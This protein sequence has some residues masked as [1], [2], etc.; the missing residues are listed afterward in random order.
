VAIENLDKIKDKI[1]YISPV[2]PSK[3]SLRLFDMYSHNIGAFEK[4]IKIDSFTTLSRLD[5]K[6]RSEIENNKAA[7]I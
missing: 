5:E 6:M 7:L 4:F 1:P 2:A 3:R